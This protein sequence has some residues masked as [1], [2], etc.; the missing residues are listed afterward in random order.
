MKISII[1][2]IIMGGLGFIVDY[3][4]RKMDSEKGLLNKI[5]SLKMLLNLPVYG[6][7]GLLL[8]YISLIP[9]FKYLNALVLFMITGAIICSVVEF[10]YG[11][12][13]NKVLKLNLWDYDLEIK[14]FGKTIPLN[15]YGQTDIIHFVLWGLISIPAYWLSSFIR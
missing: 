11:M 15:L 9:L 10:G 4:T 8:F 2:F 14:L 5:K 1:I 6:T 12:L 13:F 3:A 7:G